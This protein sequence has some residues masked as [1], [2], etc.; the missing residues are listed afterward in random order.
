[1]A[2]NFGET[3]KRIRAGQKVTLRELANHIGRTIGYVS[4]IE[5][6]RKRPPDLE[7]V[8]KMEGLL[9]TKPGLLVNMALEIRNQTS[10]NLSQKLRM[11]PILS[12]ILLRADNLSDE[13]IR[14]IINKMEKPEA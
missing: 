9:R 12:E 13:E 6:N 8:S 10:H 7:T 5:H 1:M 4:D 2:A 11:R 3:L 14:D